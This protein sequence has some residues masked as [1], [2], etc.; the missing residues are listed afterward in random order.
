M[1]SRLYWISVL[2]FIAVLSMTHAQE[3]KTTGNSNE[4][5]IEMKKTIEKFYTAFEDLDA[6]GMVSCYHDEVTFEDPAFG[7]LKGDKAKNMW[8]MLCESQKGKDFKVNSSNITATLGKGAAHW[9][10]RYT[11]SQTGRRVHNII[12]AEFEFKDGKIINHVDQ[13][14]LYTWSKQALG[15]TGY[16]LGWSRFFKKKLHAQ[17]RDLLLDFERKQLN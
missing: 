8:R 17:T 7:V 1:K 9:E 6:D 13:F 14:D 11:F 12:D 2:T 4:L 5:K 15:F 3:V 10:A 16:L